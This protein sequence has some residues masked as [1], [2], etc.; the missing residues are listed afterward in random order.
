MHRRCVQVKYVKCPLIIQAHKS[1]IL[2]SRE[3]IP[4]N[5]LK[6]G[7]CSHRGATVPTGIACMIKTSYTPEWSSHGF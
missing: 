6:T 1:A 2:V 4:N 7:F 3:K 5:L